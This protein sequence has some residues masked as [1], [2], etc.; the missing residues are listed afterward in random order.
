M[1]SE[2]ER[3]PA[4]DER[5]DAQLLRHQLAGEPECVLNEDCAN[6]V[7][8]DVIKQCRREGS[9]QSRRGFG[10]L[11]S[12]L[13]HSAGISWPQRAQLASV[14]AELV[15]VAA[16]GGRSAQLLVAAVLAAGRP[17]GVE[18]LV[19]PFAEPVVAVVAVVQPEVAAQLAEFEASVRPAE[20][21]WLER[22]ALPRLASA[23][24]PGRPDLFAGSE[25]HRQL[26]AE[27]LVL[28]HLSPVVSARRRLPE[29]SGPPLPEAAPMGKVSHWG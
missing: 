4:L 28:A 16:P 29:N 15:A 11:F 10:R 2:R 18:V 21:A 7:A 23:L 3:P 27:Q 13:E 8:L 19:S 6:A 20:S 9:V 24:F 17:E 5:Q 12:I 22:T 26:W 14:G 25:P 1:P